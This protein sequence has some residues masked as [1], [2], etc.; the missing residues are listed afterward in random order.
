MKKDKKNK[1][2]LINLI[3]LKNIG[4]ASYNNYVEEKKIISFFRKK[5]VH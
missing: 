4:S 1:N 5:L 2:K 3:L